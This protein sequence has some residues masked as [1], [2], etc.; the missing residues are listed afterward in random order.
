MKEKTLHMKWVAIGI[1]LLSIGTCIIPANAQNTKTQSSK[2]NWLYVGGSGPGNYTRIQDAFDASQDGDLVF[3]YN[4]SSPYYENLSINHS[5]ILMGEDQSSTVIS[6]FDY[7]AILINA[8]N[9]TIRDC[10]IENPCDLGLLI[11]TSDVTITHVLFQNTRFHGIEA[12]DGINIVER[13]CIQNNTFSGPGHGFFGRRC[14]DLIIANN[15][16][17]G[18]GIE[19]QHCFHASIYYNHFISSWLY[20]YDEIASGWNHL[21]QNEFRNCD[22]AINLDIPCHDLVERNNI[23]NNTC[24]VRFSRFFIGALEFKLE[25]MRDHNT[26]LWT[27]Y[28]LFSPTTWRENYWGEPLSHPKILFGSLILFAIITYQGSLPIEIPFIRLDRHP[29]QE[30]YNIPGGS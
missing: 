21:Y 6:A 10:T 12:D 23:V 5:I 25:A 24:D 28:R 29:A 27:N 18:C 8:P 13:L 30:P 20:G 7:A 9:V 22:C 11:R 3:V 4:D 2:G 16:F 1:T 17:S 15:T 26:V 19:F 14:N